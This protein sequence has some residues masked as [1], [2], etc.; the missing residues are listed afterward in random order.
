M[1]DAIK[2]FA[3]S[4][5]ATAPS[6][7]TTGTSFTLQ[8][9]GGALFPA[10]PFS[11]TCWPVGELPLVSNAEIVRVTAVSTDTFT[12]VRA[13]EGTTAQ[14]LAAG[15]QV[16]QTI[17]AGFIAQLIVPPATTVT[18][19]DAFGTAAA[20]GTGTSYA[21]DDHDHGL[22]ALPTLPAPSASG[23]VLTATGTA[24]GD[25]DWAPP[26]DPLSAPPASGDVLTATGTAV[27]DYDWAPLPSSLLGVTSYGP[28]NPVTY[29]L[30]ASLGVVDSTNLTTAITVPPSGEILVR[31]SA[32]FE[33]SQTFVTY[34]YVTNNAGASG[35][36]VSV[37]DTSTNMV[38]TTVTVGSGPM[39][40][41][42]TPNGDYVYVADYGGASVSVIDTST[43]T[44]TG[45][46][47]VGNDPW[48]VA[49]TPNG[50]YVYVTNNGADTVSVIDTSTIMVTT[51]VTVG[52]SPRGLAITPNGDYVYVVNQGGNSVSVIDTSTNTVTT[53]VAVGGSPIGVAITPNG[54]YVYVADY[55]NGAASPSIVSVIDT[56]TN[57]V[58]T[59]VTV[60]S[61][62]WGL[63]IT[64]NGDY[65]YVTNYAANTVSVIDTSTNTVT[66]TVAVTGSPMG[67][68]VTPNGDYVYVANNSVALV[69]V[70]DT[71]TN[72]VTD[73]VTVGTDPLEVAIVSLP[74]PPP[75]NSLSL[76]AFISGSQVGSAVELTTKPAFSQYSGAPILVTGLT[77][78]SSEVIEFAAASTAGQLIAGGSNGAAVMEVWS[79]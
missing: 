39:G 17:T 64:P 20:A 47:T 51:T 60:G 65:V 9:G 52:A 69:S 78:G 72:T 67:L 11:A 57:T 55:N 29:S 79:A 18:G 71:S 63:A 23:D 56:S 1:V 61:G 6:P 4:T 45:T 62:P 21:R 66:A 73:T 49:I 33:W 53:T 25:Y 43:N 37:I 59:T 3:Y 38:T 68:A 34:V 8:A 70:I 30:G 7:A 35:D 76:A 24:V 28:A 48:G 14:S 13:Q 27:G 75:S 12:I 16:A 77:A 5:I 26:V 2:D 58:T 46:V 54:D 15:Y 40:L 32:Y 19:P 36:T 50:D 42:I 44:V 22:P 41:A 10:P 31:L 74:T